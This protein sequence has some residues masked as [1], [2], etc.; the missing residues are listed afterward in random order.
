M[1]I[2]FWIPKNVMQYPIWEVMQ[3]AH[4][5]SLWPTPSTQIVMH[6]GGLCIMRVMQNERYDCNKQ[7][8]QHHLL[9]SAPLAGKSQELYYENSSKRRVTLCRRAYHFSRRTLCPLPLQPCTEGHRD[10]TLVL[11]PEIFGRRSADLCK[12]NGMEWLISKALQATFC[13]AQKQSI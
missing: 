9:W 6:Y 12:H 1:H 7:R 4:I 10:P 13:D 5:I 8:T 11:Q 2:R 3:Y